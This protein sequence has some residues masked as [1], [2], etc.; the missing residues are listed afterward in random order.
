MLIFRVIIWAI[1]AITPTLI[2]RRIVRISERNSPI[3]EMRR[4]VFNDVSRR[5]SDLARA[6]ALL[7]FR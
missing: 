2:I 3:Q 1:S 7:L 6:S 5:V 4:G